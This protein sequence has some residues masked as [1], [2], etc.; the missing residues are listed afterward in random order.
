MEQRER[1][2]ILARCTRWVPAWSAPRRSGRDVSRARRAR[3]AARG[4]L[5]RRRERQAARGAGGR[6]PRKG[7]GRDLSRAARW[8][9]R[10][11]CG[12]GASAAARWTV[13]FHPQ[14]HLDVDEERGYAHLHG[15]QARLGRPPRPAD[16]ARRASTR[17]TS[18]SA[19]CCSSFR[20]AT[21]A[22][23]SPPGA[24]SSRRRSGRAER[25]VALHLDGARL[26]QCGPFYRRPLSAI[27]ALFDT[28]YVSLYKD[29]VGLGGCLLAGPEDVIAE[30]RVW[31]VAAR[32]AAL[33]VRGDGALGR[34]R[35]RR[36]PAADAVVRAQGEGDRHRPRAHRRHRRR[37]RPAA[38]G[39]AARLRPRRARA[40]PRR[41]PRDRERIAGR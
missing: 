14:C 32:R 8:R 26:W 38:G 13:A 19:R 37:P 9:S 5:R 40:S 28:V 30:A 1:D 39:D 24:I 20:S 18:R 12:S 2:K 7:S 22:G 10:S 6:A 25:G 3:G 41:R 27:A 36:A 33:L 21:S 35:A 31:R 15:L 16:L 11:R 23:S 17:W 4:R 34:A 29:L